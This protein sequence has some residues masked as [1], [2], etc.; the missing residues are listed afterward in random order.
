MYYTV[1]H[2][3]SNK[4]SMLPVSTYIQAISDLDTA[5]NLRKPVQFSIY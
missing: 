4:Y 1:M 5:Q 3:I 2:K